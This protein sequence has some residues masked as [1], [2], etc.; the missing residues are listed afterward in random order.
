MIF[1]VT[2]CEVCASEHTSVPHVCKL[3]CSSFKRLQK[4][5][6]IRHH[7][8]SGLIGSS[9]CNINVQAKQRGKNH[10]CMTACK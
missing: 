9:G 10:V 6:D 3:F 4:L 1:E 5:P 7:R 2:D 8:T